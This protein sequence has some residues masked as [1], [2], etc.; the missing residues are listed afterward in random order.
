MNMHQRCKR[1]M[2]LLALFPVI[3]AS[4]AYCGWDEA[5][6]AYKKGDYKKAYK[7][8]KSF[9]EHGDARAQYNLG[10]MYA[11]GQGVLQDYTEASKWYRKA[12]DQGF[13]EAQNNLGIMYSNGHGVPK[14]Y[15][16]SLKWDRK[17][18][19]QGLAEAQYVLGTMYSNGYGILQD[20]AETVKWYRK[21]A[22]QGFAVAQYDLASMY[23]N[24]K[25][26]PQNYAEALNWFH[27]AADQGLAE[28]QNILKTYSTEIPLEIS[29]G[30]YELPVRI[31]GVL[32]LK[33]ILDTG[34]SE[35]NIPADVALT[36]LRTGT[37]TQSDFLPGKSYKLADGSIVR[38]L[39]LNI[40]E[41][42]I[43]GIKI[44]QVPASIDS[45]TGSPL[46]GQSFLRRLESWSLDNKRH[47]LIRGGG[48]VQ[49][50]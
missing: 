16:E 7:Q 46:L 40:R 12:A 41:L 49:P 3:L 28:A 30:V 4:N 50:R 31:N 2:V 14:D 36:L 5:T 44:S 6:S 43:G 10:V 9:A 42:D 29:G 38:S 37:I 1:M 13:A 22:E 33:F 11:N 15:A 24:G 32:I 26:V 45:V 21:A 48:T 8:L 19:D 25:G 35:V 18:A 17:A 34:A 47:V 20:Y 27:K 39:R 23:Y